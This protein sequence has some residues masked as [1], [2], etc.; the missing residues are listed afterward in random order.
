MRALGQE[1]LNLPAPYWTVLCLHRLVTATLV[2]FNRL[3]KP[4]C[5]PATS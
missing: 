5:I 2:A 4:Y 1:S 3:P